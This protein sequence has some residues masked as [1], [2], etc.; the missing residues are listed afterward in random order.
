MSLS[1]KSIVDLCFLKR[2]ELES[3]TKDLLLC[4]D[5]Y[6]LSLKGEILEQKDLFTIYL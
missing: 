5:S 1:N 6:A 2:E 4:E 3:K